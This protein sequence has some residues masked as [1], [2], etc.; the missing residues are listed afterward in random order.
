MCDCESPEFFEQYEPKARKPH[1]CCECK[2][3]I[4]VGETY[5]R[6]S[7]KWDGE[8]ATFSQCEACDELV[9]KVMRDTECCV[10][11]GNLVEELWEGYTRNGRTRRVPD[12]WTLP[13]IR[14]YESYRAYWR[15]KKRV[16]DP[17]EAT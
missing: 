15:N 13:M 16:P 1:R 17:T 8:F 2:R 4:R 9:A 7:G 12:G 5:V 6:S 14:C 3:E 11:F 10:P